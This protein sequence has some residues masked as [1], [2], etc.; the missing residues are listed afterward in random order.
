LNWFHIISSLL[1][2]LIGILALFSFEFISK[3]IDK[4]LIPFL[5]I[6]ALSFIFA[7]L[8]V[9]FLLTVVISIVL[10]VLGAKDVHPQ[11][12]FLALCLLY[13]FVG[14]KIRYF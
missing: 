6:E 8:I 12:L 2:S 11:N 1:I 9:I 4:K 13:L 5:K 7:R 3:K 14:I 10:Y